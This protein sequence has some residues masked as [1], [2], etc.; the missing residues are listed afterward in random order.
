MDQ[1]YYDD[2]K[3]TPTPDEKEELFGISNDELNKIFYAINPH[4]TRM[5]DARTI[6]KQKCKISF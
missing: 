4:V 6:S 3:M 2:P 1:N 5:I